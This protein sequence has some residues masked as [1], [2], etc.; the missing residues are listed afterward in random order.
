MGMRVDT[1]GNN[2]SPAVGGT[3]REVP[4]NPAPHRPSQTGLAGLGRRVCDLAGRLCNPPRHAAPAPQSPPPRLA[5]VQAARPVPQSRSDAVQSAAER[6]ADAVGRL[7][8]MKNHFAKLKE[9]NC[10]TVQALDSMMDRACLPAIALAENM[11][12]PGLNLRV[13]DSFAEFANALKS[14]DQKPFRAIAPLPISMHRIAMDVKFQQGA[15]SVIAVDSMGIEGMTEH[16]DLTQLSMLDALPA[17]AR[18]TVLTSN[19]QTSDAGCTMFAASAA[20]KMH[21]NA[22]PINAMHDRQL[23][24][25]PIGPSALLQDE[26]SGEGRIGLID[27]KPLLPSGFVK[28][29]QVKTTL[30]EWLAAHGGQDIPASTKRTGGPTLLGRQGTHSVQ[31]FDDAESTML[32]V[33]TSIESKRIALLTRAIEHLRHAPDSEIDRALAGMHRYVPDLGQTL[34]RAEPRVTGQVNRAEAPEVEG[35]SASGNGVGRPPHQKG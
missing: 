22:K 27:G 29:T 10:S 2:H 7:E 11:R 34:A 12:K 21:E 19:V 26:D 13:F 20:L 30:Q 5:A 32:T 16:F 17:S 35:V 1:G 28:H 23:E 24:S 15:A 6:R 31:R 4:R 25:E 3:D 18:L 14:V 8:R 33:S 9:A